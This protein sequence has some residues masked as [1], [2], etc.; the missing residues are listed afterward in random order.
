MNTEQFVFR[1]NAREWFGIWIV[2]LLLSVVTLGIYSAW[3]KVRR[4]KYFYNNTYV[5]GRNF[6]YHA[7]GLQILIGRAIVAVCFVAFSLLSAIP[8]VGILMGLALV[9]VFPWLMVRSLM[10]N[11]RMSSWSNVRFNFTGR[12]GRAFLVY[13]LYPF[14]T[15]LSLGIAYP[16]LDRA[17]KRFTVGHHRLGTA[18]LRMEAPLGPFYKAFFAAILW[19]LLVLGGALVVMGLGVEDLVLRLQSLEADP[20]PGAFAVLGVYVV[21]FAAFLPAMFI[22]KAMTR[23]AVF[24]ATRLKGGHGFRSSVTAGRLMWIALSNMVVVVLTFGL[25]LPWAQ[26]RMMRYLVA[27]TQLVPGGSLDDFVD[28][29][30]RESSALGDAYTDL[31]G[32]DLGLPI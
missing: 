25:M 7:T 22:Y 8:I 3:A 10:F 27:Q 13:L 12:I 5:A 14:L 11:A 29:M 17:V 4:K 16:V 30:Q 9:F 6:D 18:E 19:V 26:I 32:V 23:N 24:N 20:V 1:G 2:N 28:L 21:F 15:V 31:E